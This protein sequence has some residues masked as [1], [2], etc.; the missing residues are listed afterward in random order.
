MASAYVI[1]LKTRRD[2]IA[3]ELAI[4]AKNRPGGKPNSAN[5]GGATTVDHVGYKDGL[6]R[7][8]KAL[9]ELIRAAAET[10]AM[11]D[12]GAGGPFEIATNL[13]P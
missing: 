6:Y 4:L 13:M 8:L 7:E 12:A 11:L 2:A 10:E 9:D 3:A 5:G 1:A